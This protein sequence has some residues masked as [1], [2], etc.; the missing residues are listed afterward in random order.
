MVKLFFILNW[1]HQ[2]RSIGHWYCLHSIL[3]RLD[4]LS[5]PSFEKCFPDSYFKLKELN[6]CKQPL[7]KAMLLLPPHEPYPWLCWITAS[8]VLAQVTAGFAASIV[9]CKALLFTTFCNTWALRALNDLQKIRESLALYK[10][11]NTLWMSC[12]S[13]SERRARVPPFLMLVGQKI[14]NNE[15]SKSSVVQL[16]FCCGKKLIVGWV[17][18]KQR[19]I[20][21]W[22][23]MDVESTCL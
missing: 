3:C 15:P 12:I 20:V 22:I 23:F 11:F 19:K 7:F 5:W 14:Q 6:Y 10:S 2:E 16:C 13:H 4:M 1:Q 21:L 18:K 8:T 17:Q 9:Q